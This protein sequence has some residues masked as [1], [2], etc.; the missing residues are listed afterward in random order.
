MANSIFIFVDF[1]SIV[2]NGDGY[3]NRYIQMDKLQANDHQ[4]MNA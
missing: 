4:H 1:C 3:K 2:S